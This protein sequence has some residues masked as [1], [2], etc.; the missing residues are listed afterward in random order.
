MSGLK[1]YYATLVA[2]GF[3]CVMRWPSRRR[4]TTK[5]SLQADGLRPLL[6]GP[7]PVCYQLASN[8]NCAPARAFGRRLGLLSKSYGGSNAAS[9]Y[10][11]N[12]SPSRT[13]TPTQRGRQRSWRTGTPRCFPS[14]SKKGLSSKS[15]PQLGMWPV[16]AW[17]LRKAGATGTLWICAPSM[18]I[19]MFRG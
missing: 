5:S 12:P 18:F 11:S 14:A 2:T 4:L 1:D 10:L 19:L 8:T 6:D 16:P 15:Q 7:A 9:R 3:V 17:S 13:T